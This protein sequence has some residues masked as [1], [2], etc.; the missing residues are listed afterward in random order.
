MKSQESWV[1]ILAL[2]DLSEFGTVFPSLS[3]FICTTKI[4]S[5]A[6]LLTTVYARGNG[7]IRRGN[8][9]FKVTRLVRGV[10]RFKRIVLEPMEFTSIS[11]Y[12]PFG[13]SF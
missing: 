11:Y 3:F 7:S 5:R 12:L 9:L 4:I 10:D 8:I 13:K 1:R 2:T 6:L